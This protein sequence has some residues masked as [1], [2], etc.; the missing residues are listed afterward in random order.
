MATYTFREVE[1]ITITTS[2]GGTGNATTTDILF[3]GLWAII[4]D[5][6]TADATTELTGSI[7]G[8]DALGADLVVFVTAAG[9]T[10]GLYVPRRATIKAADGSAGVGE[11]VIPFAGRQL[12][13]AAASTGATKTIT[14]K[15]IMIN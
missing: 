4:V 10:D 9:N 5:F 12:K 3:G 11:E 1:P 7:V 2:A 13:I 8:G 6:G 15:P 14:I